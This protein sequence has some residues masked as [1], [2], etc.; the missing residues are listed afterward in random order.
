M[1]ILD[2][3]FNIIEDF[4]EQI[5]PLLDT[6]IKLQKLDLNANPVTITPKYRD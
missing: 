3:R 2:L 4:S 1:E 5:V 6:M